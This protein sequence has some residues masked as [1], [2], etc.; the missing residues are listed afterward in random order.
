M[1]TKAMNGKMTTF[2]VT[3]ISTTTMVI[4]NHMVIIQIQIGRNTIDDV[5]LDGG[6]RVN[7]N[8]KQLRVGLRH[9]KKNLVLAIRV[10][11]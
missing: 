8:T 1:N 9:Y 3:N 6:S 5:L 4:N 10:C 7:I 11:N 2:V